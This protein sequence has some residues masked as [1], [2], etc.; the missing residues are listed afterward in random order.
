MMSS[1][2]GVGAANSHNNGANRASAVCV[3]SLS[4]RDHSSKSS[5]LVQILLRA[6]EGIVHKFTR[7]SHVCGGAAVVVLKK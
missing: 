4:I 3:T 6:E 2:V 1:L 7:L 5:L